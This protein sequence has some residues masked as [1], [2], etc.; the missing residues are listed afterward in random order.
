M[1]KKHGLGGWGTAFLTA[2]IRDK[3]E[4]INN[5]YKT[6]TETSNLGHLGPDQFVKI[7]TQA[8]SELYRLERV[9]N[10]RIIL[11]IIIESIMACGGIR[12]FV[13]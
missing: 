4:D 9:R 11:A 5:I 13:R 6:I 10:F 3:R 7:Y 12:Y 8:F 1:E 2:E